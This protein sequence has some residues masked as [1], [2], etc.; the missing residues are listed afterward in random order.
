MTSFE[1]SGS[2]L[3]WFLCSVRKLIVFSDRIEVNWVFVSGHRKKILPDVRVGIKMD[4]KSVMGSNSLVF[5][6]A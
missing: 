1:C 6:P 2:A 5:L 3:I 4:L